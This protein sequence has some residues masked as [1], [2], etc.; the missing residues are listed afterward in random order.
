[1]RSGPSAL[2]VLFLYDDG[3]SA[4]ALR[5]ASTEHGEFD[6]VAAISPNSGVTGTSVE[7]AQQMEYEVLNR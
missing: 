5:Q 6:I 1:M 3:L 7:V 4:E 2:T